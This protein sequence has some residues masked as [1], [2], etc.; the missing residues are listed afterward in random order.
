M[1]DFLFL[2]L[3]PVG[4]HFGAAVWALWGICLLI[5]MHRYTARFEEQLA[6]SKLSLCLSKR[7]YRHAARRNPTT[8][9]IPRRAHMQMSCPIILDYLAC[10]LFHFHA[11]W[12]QPSVSASFSSTAGFGG[13]QKSGA[14]DPRRVPWRLLGMRTSC[15]MSFS[16]HMPH[17]M[18]RAH[19]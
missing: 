6:L 19:M 4:S 3:M 2:A 15:F 16:M 7:V 17:A 5:S 12:H 1:R 18:P 14:G 8:R 9:R 10:T 13:A 11:S